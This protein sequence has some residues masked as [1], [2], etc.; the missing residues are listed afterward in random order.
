MGE[1][2]ESLSK[3]SSFTDDRISGIPSMGG[4]SADAES[5]VTVAYKTW[6]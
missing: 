4:F 5:P 3:K 1:M 2:G 6:H